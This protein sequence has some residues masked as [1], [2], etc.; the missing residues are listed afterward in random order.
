MWQQ[1]SLFGEPTGTEL[2]DTGIRR[3]VDNADRVNG[4]WSDGAYNLL[5]TIAG[6]G[7]E[8]MVEDVRKFAESV[9]FPVPPSARAW[10]AIAVKAVKAGVIRRVGY[11]QVKNPKA[12]GTPA[13]LWVKS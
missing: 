12:H 5:V 3:A 13:S 2:R 8:F 7:L 4:S 1:G 10:G 11:S 6:A 9:N